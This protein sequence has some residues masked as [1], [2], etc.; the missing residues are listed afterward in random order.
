MIPTRNYQTCLTPGIGGRGGGGDTQ[1]GFTWGRTAPRSNPL[2]F[3]IPFLT[4][5]V[6]LSYTFCWQLVAFHIPGLELCIPFNCCKC[7]VFN[8]ELITKPE[9][10][11][12]FLTVMK[13]ICHPFWAFLPTEMTNSP[14]LSY[15]WSLKKV[16]LS[17]GAPS[18]RPPPP[19][20]V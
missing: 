9:R 5:K 2:S 19:P 6:P 10:F 8:Y 3:N 18:Y 14:T 7:S 4:E 12:D 1:Q 17:R 13:C 15:T 11:H 16:L 20:G